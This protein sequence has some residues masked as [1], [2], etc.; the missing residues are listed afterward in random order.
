MLATAIGRLRRVNFRAAG[1]ALL[2]AAALL[3][4]LRV[5]AHSHASEGEMGGACVVCIHLDAPIAAPP[6]PAQ[7]PALVFER[8]AEPAP[9][10]VSLGREADPAAETRGPPAGTLA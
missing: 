8:P 9:A 6:P 1:V 2:A 4:A 10:V 5:T 7:T 3:L